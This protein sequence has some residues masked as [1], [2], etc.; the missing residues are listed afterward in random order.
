[1]IPLSVPYLKGNELQ[2][3][4]ECI[5]GNWIS[6]AG[7]FVKKF[8]Q[9][10][11]E[12]NGSPY[13]IACSS[14]TAALH[15]ALLLLGVGTDDEVLVPTV[16]F[17]ASPNSVRYVGAY[18]VFM[19]CDDY[20]NIDVQ[21]MRQFCEEECKL[22]KGTLINKKTGRSVKAIMPVHIFGHP[23][24]MEAVM[25][26]AEDFGLEVIE[27]ATESLG[28]YY[29]A[30]KY[31]GKKTGTIGKIGC[32]SFNGNKIISTGGGGMIVTEDEA[33][34]KRAHYLTTQ[35]KDDELSFV[36]NEI[37]YNYRLTNVQAALGVAQ[38]EVLEDYIRIKRKNFQKYSEA[39]NGFRGL[40]LLA[41]PPGTFSNFWHYALLVEKK[42][43]GLTPLELVSKLETHG[44]QARPLWYLNHKQQPYTRYQ[45]YK[46]EKALY[47]HDRVVNIPCS[48][49]L[50]D[51]EC[52]K[53][54]E[55]I[56]C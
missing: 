7:P 50:T 9:I 29:T 19:D 52:L 48:V 12:K 36:H 15:I 14:G 35:A 38:L 33:L 41:E 39:L 56:R 16:T 42:N 2:Y 6:S 30:G 1:M 45:H 11:A 13:A 5:T 44:I 27:D 32:F 53:V 10:F 20:L 8:E 51:E 18:P 25:Q 47:Y 23:A 21:K 4:T 54:I 24:N 3:V 17:I 34:A 26:I 55:A 46:I 43:Y 28:S 37:G 40:K 49:G 31:K 22:I